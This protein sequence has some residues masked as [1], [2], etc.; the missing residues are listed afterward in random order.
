[1]KGRDAVYRRRSASNKELALTYFQEGFIP[2]GVTF[3]KETKMLSK[4]A[5][6]KIGRNDPCPCGSGLKYKKCCLGTTAQS[7]TDIKEL[8][9]KRYKIHLKNDREV[10]KIRDAGRLVLETRR[11]LE[12][13]G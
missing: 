11:V 12:V 3:K 9:A 7:G 4:N 8:Y 5:H 1:M 10:E 6:A 13:S 2:F